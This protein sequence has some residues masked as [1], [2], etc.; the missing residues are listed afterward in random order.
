MKKKYYLAVAIDRREKCA[1][2]IASKEGGIDIEEIAA[3]DPKSILTMPIYEDGKLRDFQLLRLFK[4]MGWQ[5]DVASQ[6]GKL[7][8]GLVNAFMAMDGSL[9]EINPLVKTPKG[10]LLAL[11][12]KATIDDN[13]L[14]RQEELRTWEDLKQLPEVERLAKA[15]DLSY[16]ALDGN[17]GC[18][19]NGA[20]LA[21]A[22]MDLIQLYGGRP[23]NFLDVGGGAS[24]EKVSEGFSILLNDPQVKAVLVNIFG[25]IMNC[26]IIAAGLIDALSR[27]KKMEK[28]LVV[29]LEGT[30]VESA[31]KMLKDSG[32]KLVL[33]KNLGDGA[34]KV[35]E[36]CRS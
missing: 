27:Q 19:V 30:N 33:A 20:G 4:T 11:D 34:K 18:M 17:I 21:M 5:G 3:K 8:Q 6:G 15:Q 10:E 1:V 14:F 9:I 13:A 28:P 35:V 24:L 16:I 25:G 22:T 2:L 26:D 32:L 36:L 29:R 23:A 31:Q 7:A 12:A